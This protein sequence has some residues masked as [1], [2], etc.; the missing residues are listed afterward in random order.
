MTG[1]LKRSLLLL[2][3]LVIAAILAFPLRETI[4]RMVVIPLAFI[5]WN[6][7]LFYRS[8]SQGI[9][10]LAVVLIVLFMIVF[11]L[12]P[13]G[14]SRSRV[15]QRPK[16]PQG[17]WKVWRY[18]AK[19]ELAFISNG[20]LPTGLKLIQ[21]CCI[22][23]T[24]VRSVFAPLVGTDWEPERDQT[25]LKSAAWVVRRLSGGKSP[26]SAYKDSQVSMR[27]RLLDFLNHKWRMVLRHAQVETQRSNSLSVFVTLSS[28]S[29]VLIN[30]LTGVNCD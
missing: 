24:V 20:W 30:L 23:R 2:A 14:P 10:W 13:R 6:L 18:P 26:F 5:A 1:Q 8:F 19:A 9:W 21:C 4:Y 28:P 3:A 17:Q 27:R 15:A 29:G 22:V 7:A 16:P 11:S 12:V 25:T